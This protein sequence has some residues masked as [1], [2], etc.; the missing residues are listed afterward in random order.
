MMNDSV[1]FEATIYYMVDS[2][3]P[4]YKYIKEPEAKQQFSDIY[5]FDTFYW[6]D[7][8]GGMKAYMKQDL[9]L[10]AGGGYNCDHI[11]NVKYKI[12]RLH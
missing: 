6:G 8:F 12:T 10:V 3:H 1:K 9:A 7:D 11:N 5:K 2:D 4:D